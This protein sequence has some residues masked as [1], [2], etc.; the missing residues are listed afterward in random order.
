MESIKQT[1]IKDQAYY[2]FDDMIN[3]KNFDPNLPKIGKK[4]YK[5]I[6]IY[7]IEFVAMKDT[8]NVNIHSLNPLYSIIG[9]VD[10]FIGSGKGNKYLIFATK[11]K[12]KKYWQNAQN[13][14]I[15]LKVW[16]KK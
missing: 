13:F 9:K 8:D 3:I 15:K 5:N 6:D 7:F 1:N 14:V 12:K 4:S 11:D 2:F 16:L 10:G